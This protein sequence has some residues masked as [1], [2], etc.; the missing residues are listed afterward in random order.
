MLIIL[1]SSCIC[2]H[3][4]TFSQ[5]SSNVLEDTIKEDTIKIPTK[6]EVVA[7]GIPAG[8]VPAKAYFAG[9]GSH[10]GDVWNE[11]AMIENR[12]FSQWQDYDVC[13]FF[14]NPMMNRVE[15]YPLVDI[16]AY[17][18]NKQ[19]AILVYHQIDDS[20]DIR[21]IIGIDWMYG[22]KT[23]SEPIVILSTI[24][25]T[26]TSHYDY[27]TVIINIL[28]GKQVVLKEQKF[29]YVL[30]LYDEILLT[31]AIGSN[32]SYILTTTSDYKNIKGKDFLIPNLSVYNSNGILVR[33][34][35]L[36]NQ[37]IPQQE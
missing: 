18:A 29:V 26:Q 31:Y 7:S 6:E 28:T 8:A 20:I 11:V 21:N 36:P 17:N 37:F 10:C 35:P 32:E 33:R 14:V 30:H 4:H 1:F 27:N 25:T 15:E 3:A 9:L 13:Y 16:W 24:G 19:K 34:I 23:K 2:L 22:G 5:D 12:L